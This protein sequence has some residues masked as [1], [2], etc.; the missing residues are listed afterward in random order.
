MN[1]IS[2]DRSTR[3]CRPDSPPLDVFRV[4]LRGMV[5]YAVVGF[6]ICLGAFY[7]IGIP[8]SLISFVL[9][10]ALDPLLKPGH[11][12][13]VFIVLI[14]A[15]LF[16]AVVILVA[17]RGFRIAGLMG[18]KFLIYPEGLGLQWFWSFRMVPWDEVASI[19]HSIPTKGEIN[20]L[21][22]QQCT[23]WIKIRRGPLFFLSYRLIDRLVELGEA[24]Q[25]HTLPHR[26][27]EAVT[28]LRDGGQVWFG[29]LWIDPMGIHTGNM[30]LPWSQIEAFEF[31]RG[32]RYSF[33]HK[34]QGEPWLKGDSSR[35]P[36]FHLLCL[37]VRRMLKGKASLPAEI[38]PV[39][40]L[41]SEKDQL[42]E[43]GP[44]RP[45]AITS[46]RNEIS[47][48]PK[49]LDLPPPPVGHTPF[50]SDPLWDRIDGLPLEALPV[51]GK[52]TMELQVTW[53]SWL[54]GLWCHCCLDPSILYIWGLLCF[55]NVVILLGSTQRP[56]MIVGLM[57]VSW[58]YLT[59]GPFL[60]LLPKIWKDWYCCSRRVLLYPEGFVFIR[61]RS[62]KGYR[63]ERMPAWH[64]QEHRLLFFGPGNTYL[65]LTIYPQ[66]SRPVRLTAF[67]EGMDILVEQLR[68]HLCNRMREALNNGP[69]I[70]IGHL[71]LNGRG[72]GS[73]G[74]WS[75]WSNLLLC[76]KKNAL[77]VS[78][79]DTGEVWLRLRLQNIPHAKLLLE[80]LTESGHLPQAAGDS[81][82]EKSQV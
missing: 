24:I 42:A 2:P 67:I 29:K 51:L 21:T 69:S 76:V 1:L 49:Q 62:V 52:P 5:Y 33:Y 48:R 79:K 12:F 7:A 45:T 56:E 30:S 53:T 72:L 82:R 27:G 65:V 25:K 15:S 17:I 28:V 46:W 73:M 41:L 35:V 63:W 58:V 57:C 61:R 75:S 31:V 10:F 59:I 8:F 6:T 44:N 26:F 78:L 80:L 81:S 66:G 43:S 71:T 38:G 36:N 23:Y 47:D 74:K 37:Y 19:W 3:E 50:R 55:L 32:G 4:R 16:M 64:C 14:A 18:R 77:V 11:P 70:A 34:G 68:M 22:R 9:V 13:F 60:S 40:S 54:R 20:E 39:H